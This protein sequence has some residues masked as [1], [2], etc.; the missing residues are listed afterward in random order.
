MGSKQGDHRDRHDEQSVS[1]ELLWGRSD[2][3]ESELE[4]RQLF[5][6]NPCG[7]E[8]GFTAELAGDSGHVSVEPSSGRSSCTVW[9]Q[10]AQSGFQPNPRVEAS[11]ENTGIRGVIRFE[12]NPFTIEATAFEK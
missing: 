11:R 2:I 7:V 4:E 9:P 3:D 12:M 5:Q 8:A 1:V 10:M 6:S